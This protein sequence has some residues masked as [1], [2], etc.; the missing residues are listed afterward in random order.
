MGEN[1][2][3]I[4]KPGEEKP[5]VQV[6]PVQPR[7]PGFKEVIQRPYHQKTKVVP[8]P[9]IEVH[10]IFVLDPAKNLEYPDQIHA[11]KPEVP[12]EIAEEETQVLT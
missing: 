10:E 11:E 3:K 9:P 12:A 8:E 1:L 5:Q 4:E 6:Q 2:P 7:K